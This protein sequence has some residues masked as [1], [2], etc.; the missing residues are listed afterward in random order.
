MSGVVEQNPVTE[1]FLTMLAET[2]RHRV[3]DGEAEQ[4]A[5]A[6]Y[7]VLYELDAPP[8]ETGLMVGAPDASAEM[9]FQVTAVGR[10]R[11]EVSGMRD[12]ARAATLGLVESGYLNPILPDVGSVV[13]RRRAMSG[14]PMREGIVWSAADRFVLLVT[15]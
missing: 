2:C 15:V 12:T 9:L 3:F 5:T 10:S 11:R 6:P 7:Y 8:P 13:A 1:A 4:G 14:Q